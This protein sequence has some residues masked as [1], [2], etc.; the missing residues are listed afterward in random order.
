VGAVTG[1]AGGVAAGGGSENIEEVI[2]AVSSTVSSLAAADS[3]SSRYP[4]FAP[5]AVSGLV[6]TIG[7]IMM[8]AI[9]RV[10]GNGLGCPDW[11]LC[12]GQAIPPFFLSAWVEFVHRLF[13]VVVVAQ[14]AALIW[15]A[16]RRYRQDRWLFGTAVAG[17]VLLT[18][19]VALGGIHVVYE[20]PRWT[21]WIHTALAMVIAGIVAFW[22]AYAR[23]HWQSMGQAVSHT[24]LSRWT[25]LAAAGTYILLLTGSLV[26]RTGASLVCPTFP[27]C[28]LRQIPAVL[29]KI[30]TVQMVHRWTA[31]VVAFS[32][33]LVLYYLLRAAKENAGLRRFALGLVTLL[34]LQF[35]LGMV[36]VWFALPMWSRVLHIGT[37]AAIWSVA[38][39]LVTVLKL[40]ALLK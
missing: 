27:Y 24:R 22:V 30:V 6:S 16:F 12:H 20:L 8:G 17:A 21:G 38:V 13:G 5:L 33:T 31:F 34:V 23:P 29:Q 10:T 7:L 14:L 35:G 25:M 4:L 9:V 36:N 18:G 15:L 26:T 37:G 39:M 3:E 28:G 40:P 1:A 32:L 2:M 19:Q 11:P